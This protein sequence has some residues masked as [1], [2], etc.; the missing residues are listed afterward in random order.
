MMETLASKLTHLFI[1]L[2]NKDYS[3]DEVEIFDY[4]FQC[5]INS[6]STDLIL[7]FWGIITS[8]LFET[9]CWLTI[10]CIYRHHAGGAH[11]STSLRCIIASSLLGMSNII[12]LYCVH[13]TDFFFR[14]CFCISFVVTLIYAPSKSSKKNLSRG[15]AIYQKLVLVTLVWICFSLSVLLPTEISISLCYGIFVAALLL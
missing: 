1:S 14:V 4:G 15:Q 6:F 5:F 11:A 13:Y 9:L 2:S 3:E 8:S 12:P 10:F 7:I